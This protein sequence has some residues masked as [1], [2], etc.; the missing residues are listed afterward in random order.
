MYVFY[1]PG[2]MTELK[3]DDGWTTVFGGGGKKKSVSK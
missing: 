1:G 3:T 2:K